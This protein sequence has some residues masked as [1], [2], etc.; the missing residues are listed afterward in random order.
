MHP[1]SLNRNRQKNLKKNIKKT[2]HYG[3]HAV[4]AALKT[5]P[6]IN[7]QLFYLPQKKNRRIQSLIDMA[8]QK[9]IPKQSKTSAELLMLCKTEHHQGV[10][11]TYDESTSN[12]PKY[13][14]IEAL[15][16]A[17]NKPLTVLML[18]QIQDPQNLGACLRTALAAHVDAVL[19]TQHHSA[20]VNATVHHVSCGATEQLNLFTITNVSNTLKMLKEQSFWIYGASEHAPQSLYQTTFTPDNTLLIMGQEEQGLRQQTLNQCDF[21]LSIPT[22]KAMPSLNVSVATGVCL[23]E[24]RRQQALLTQST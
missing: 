10:V 6:K 19:I 20:K 3:I 12:T 24:K 11:L 8:T 1:E 22:T 15:I 23:F 17:S 13:A 14:A 21:L 2:I 9:K 5:T 18:E 7:A 4:S 16:A